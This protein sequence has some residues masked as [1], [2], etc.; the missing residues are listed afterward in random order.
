MKVKLLGT[1]T[2]KHLEKQI[3]ICAAAGKLSRMPGTVFD[4]V[5]SMKDYDKALKFIKRVIGMGHT[6]TIDHDYMVFALSGVS[7]IVEQTIIEERYS[8]FT[9]KSRREVDFSNVGF[10]IPDFHTNKG[11]IIENN[12]EIKKEYK[13]Y[14]KQLFAS[15]K[16]LVDNNIPKEDARFVLPYCYHSEII[17]GLDGTS[18]VRMI[19]R[20]TKGKCSKITE[21]KELGEKLYE[22]AKDR[23]PY[24]IELIEKE[25]IEDYSEV[26]EIIK[27][28]NF[29]TK[30]N[31]INEPVLLSYTN[32]ID[33]T[34][35]VNALAR[36]Y[37]LDYTSAKAIYEEKIKGNNKLED[38]LMK[39]IF[40][41]PEHNDL[42]QINLRF[43]LGIPF[44]ILTH[45]TRH[46]RLSLS[47]P[48]FVPIPDLGCYITPPSIKNS[49]MN[50][51]YHEVFNKNIE[52]YNKFK[53]YGICDEDLVY[54]ILSGNAV[55]VIINF[56]GEAFRWICRLRECT[57]AQWCIRQAVTK[58]H[59]EVSNVSKYFANN[60]GPDC[61]TKHICGEGKESCGRIN[62]ILEKIKKERNN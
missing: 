43:Q 62:S 25:N 19:V 24:I 31:L 52:V 8:S 22:I 35:F 9:I 56:D 5:N 27:E 40:N 59:N 58:M 47:I 26:E 17:M 15:Y 50:D 36:I 28:T 7:P 14:M 48:D 4:A 34:L 49:A 29:E 57:K 20:L 44:A 55:N 42:R 33:E 54:F 18:L 51:F 41:D 37:S 3:N 53:S 30:Y 10:Y 6:S 21:L 38:K 2:K 45:Y 39:A 16:K 46:R 12:D 13:K 32:N 61:V 11:E 60:L 1:T 23:A